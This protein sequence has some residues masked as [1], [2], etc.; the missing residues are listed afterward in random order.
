MKYRKLALIS[1]LLLFAACTE[2]DDRSSQENALA[3]PSYNISLSD[4]NKI[5]FSRMVS[6]QT[7]AGGT[8]LKEIT[9]IVESADTLLYVINYEKDGGWI[10]ASADKRVPLV[11]ARAETGRFDLQEISH[12]KGLSIWL[13]NVKADIA[14]LKEHPDYVPDSSLIQPVIPTSLQTKGGGEHEGEWLQLVYTIMD[15]QPRY[16]TGHM[17]STHWG[18]YEPWNEAVPLNGNGGR[19]PT[20]SA[21]TAV[22]Q[23]AYYLH[24]KIGKPASSP[25]Y[26][27]CIDNYSAYN[28]NH[29]L[30]VLH[31]SS[32]YRWDYMDIDSTN[33]TQTGRAAV[34]GL[35]AQIAKDLN[36]SFYADSTSTPSFSDIQNYLTN[37]SVSCHTPDN[38]N[39][40]IVYL[41]LEYGDPVLIK[42][43]SSSLG[44]CF[45]IIDG[46]KEYYYHY[47]YYY[48]WMPIGTYPPVEPEYPDLEHPELY[49]I[50]EG[51]GNIV[52]FDFKINWGEY[53]S[54]DDAW[55]SATSNW[56]NYSQSQMLYNFQ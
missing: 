40:P 6:P 7:K 42:L 54:Y 18:Q 12:H 11:V 2:I 20:G 29:S 34:A 14:Y 41:C 55:Y 31:S 30:I 5:D 10:L 32:P 9:P 50:G 52:S 45:A 47:A 23:L 37:Q 19:C 49:E 16:E 35:M 48:Q 53:G 33:T 22:A 13:D 44:S 24:Y 28:S 1:L 21:T 17:L 39:A 36:I 46:L 25:I 56:R 38:Y 8:L 15:V 3:K 26:A 27:E 43:T 4:I 51:W